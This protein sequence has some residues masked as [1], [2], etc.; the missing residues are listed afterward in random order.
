MKFALSTNINNVQY[1]DFHYIVTSN[2]RRVLGTLLADYFTGI[3]CFSLVGTYGSGKSSFLAALER[4][5]LEK[6]KVLFENKGQFNEYW[7]FSCINIVGDYNSLSNLLSKK[8]IGDSI[9]SKEL[10]A[11]L[12]QTLIDHKKR[13]E[14]V[15]L[16]IDEFGKVLEHAANHIPEKELYFLQQLAEFINHPKR[17]N[18]LLVTTLHQNFG[19]YSKKLNEQQ[20]NEWEKVKGRLKEIAFSEPVEQLLHLAAAQIDSSNNK[21][22][23]RENFD[24]LFHLAKSTNF[25]KSDLSIDIAKKLYPLDIF[26]AVVLT[27]SIQRYGQNERSLFSFLY[28]KDNN[29]LSQFNPQANKTYN[30]ANVHDYIIYNFYSYLSEVNADSAIWRAIR[31]ALERV[32]GLFEHDKIEAASNIVKTIGL[33][34]LYGNSTTFNE[35]ALCQYLQFALN[36]IKPE[37]LIREL[38][39]HKII[40]FAK[41]KSQYIIF[42]GTDVNIE[43]ELYK[44]AGIVPRPS[45]FINDLNESFEFK[46]VQA[47]SS[48]YKTGTPRFFEYRISSEAQILNP[49][50][51][52]DG[53]INLVFPY[54]EG[55]KEHLHETSRNCNNAVIYV[56]FNNVTQIVN[57]LYEIKKLEY[58]RKQVL[59]ED[60]I[61][62]REINNLIVY[63]KDLLN[64]AINHG[65]MSFST[66]VEWYY[67]GEN[68]QISSQSDFNKLLS[69]VCDD[70]YYST[71]VIQNELFNK[72]KVNSTISLARVTLLN[73]L[74]DDRCVM[75]NEL[76]FEKDKF[77]PEKTIYYTLLKNTGIHCQK[78]GIYTL[79]EPQDASIKDLWDK[80]EAFLESSIEKQRKL[81]ELI[82]DLKLAP[83]KLKKG[84]LDFWIPIYLI[85]KKQDYSLYDSED[86][87]IPYLNREV[88][89]LLQKSPNGYKI[90]AFAIDGV[91][92]EFFNQYRNF[93]NLNDRDLIT[94]DSF[95][96]TIKPFLI[97]YNNLDDFAKSTQNFDNPFT[98]KFRDVLAKAKDPEKTFFEDLPAAFG[99]KN[100]SLA[101]NEVFLTQY[102]D[103]MKDAIR[104]LR[105]SYSNLIK[106]I[107]DS[108]IDALGLKS[109]YFN[110]YKTEIDILFQ[111]VKTNLLSSKQKSFLNR[112]LM[113]Q[114]EK[115]LWY[116]SICYVVIDKPLVSI[117]DNEISF[118]IDTL[119]HLLVSLTKFVDIS[120]AAK[121]NINS[122]IYNFELVSTKGTIKPQ[123]Y[124]LPQSQKKKTEAL[125]SK[126][127]EILSGDYNVDVCT[128]LRIIKNKI[129]NND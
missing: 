29:S 23:S 12:E 18:V 19:A 108:I 67:K 78:D 82:K 17:D 13:G 121:N 125:E 104:E 100:D 55:E 124:I 31:V 106:R 120:K 74:I 94:Q 42:E 10:F 38:I 26:S 11:H 101:K 40:R 7:K 9:S 115:T 90:K 16:V 49:I 86:R 39:A 64:K 63:E 20:R 123:S 68:R 83:F 1:D 54:N 80:C 97:F 46:V 24:M 117:K 72:H 99:F 27:Y 50:N 126:I 58:I 129:E 59:V 65:L 96:E 85:I 66:N 75:Q 105:S 81:G 3:H 22:I 118:L 116:E 127:T 128:L 6:T 122:E 69:A 77:P 21:I 103:L 110:Q 33:C 102:Q 30:L 57:H 71:P 62:D 114:S 60:K 52:I 32:E 4:D 87:Y 112:L 35:K 47:N 119:K 98:L 84:F 113:G 95:L 15:I 93:I 45:D 109:N 41:Y 73:M 89:D 14:F 34:N 43:D 2:A 76:G 70:V 44:A 56:Y 37:Q 107:E 5:I 61:A 88:L 111:G 53:Y 91:K 79:S 48:F 36:I 8:L 51:D 92:I 28:S 25:I